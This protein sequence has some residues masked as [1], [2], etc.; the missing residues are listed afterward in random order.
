M[1]LP[2]PRFLTSSFFRCYHFYL[3]Q[4]TEEL[5]QLLKSMWN[6]LDPPTRSKYEKMGAEDQARYERELAAYSSSSSS[7]KKKKGE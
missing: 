3:C 6:E 4:K 5:K 1:V 2:Y 7:S